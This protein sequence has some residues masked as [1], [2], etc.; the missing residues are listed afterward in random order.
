MEEKQQIGIIYFN[1]ESNEYTLKCQIYNKL[2]KM[3]L[4]TY[5]NRWVYNDDVYTLCL[6]DFTVQLQKKIL[7]MYAN[8]KVDLNNNEYKCYT[9]ILH[10]L[11]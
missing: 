11:S 10:T 5:K 2:T 1:T 4:A 3:N 7:T 8:T 6:D 9:A